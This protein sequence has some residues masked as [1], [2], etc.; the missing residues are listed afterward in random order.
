MY[1]GETASTK[2]AYTRLQ[3]FNHSSKSKNSLGRYGFALQ[4]QSSYLSIGVSREEEGTLI[5]L[6]VFKPDYIQPA[7]F[8]E[9]PAD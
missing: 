6:T 4:C 1:M 8:S 9:P 5:V 2:E 7:V 3:F